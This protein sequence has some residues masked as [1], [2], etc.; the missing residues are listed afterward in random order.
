[1]SRALPAHLIARSRALLEELRDQCCDIN[2]Y[3]TTTSASG[4][5]TRPTSP[6]VVAANLRCRLEPIGQTDGMKKIFDEKIVHEA[7]HILYVRFDDRLLDGD[8]VTVDDYTYEV[9]AVND[10]Q[11]D[12]FSTVGLVKELS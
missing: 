5:V 7:T 9:I 8:V 3:T 4:A 2:R 10:R 11:Q 6:T 1:M 12:R